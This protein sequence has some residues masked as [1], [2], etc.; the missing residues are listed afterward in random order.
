MSEE[1]SRISLLLTEKVDRLDASKDVLIV[2][3]QELKPRK[4]PIRSLREV[5]LY[6]SCSIESRAIS[7]LS[8]G[9]VPLLLLDGRGE[10]AG[11]LQPGPIKN[12]YPRKAQMES[13]FNT[14]R[15][16]EIA[17]DM[18]REKLLAMRRMTKERLEDYDET[19]FRSLEEASDLDALRGVEG[20]ATRKHYEH[21]GRWLEPSGFLF[22][23]RTKRP[24]ADPVNSML[25]L[26]YS[27]TMSTNLAAINLVGLDPAF[28]FLHEDYYGRPSL[29]CDLM[30]PWR[31]DLAERFVL[32]ICNR[33]EIR[34]DHFTYGSPAEGCLLNSEGRK[35]FFGK[36]F[37][38]LCE[39]KRRIHGH[40]V[41]ITFREAIYR[42]ARIFA[43]KLRGETNDHSKDKP[44]EP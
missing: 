37:P 22:E 2:R 30:E 1:N 18:V 31:T 9:N 40:S 23:G 8:R 11:A 14:R 36:W 27:L 43:K 42:S 33:Q 26:S 5:I 24:P 12:F 29:A 38:F 13:Y 15:R 28:G 39:D 7:V 21:L 4:Y 34:P 17:K 19:I 16:V 44:L 35:K 3:F 32:R 25:S 20:S 41:E 6:R 10:Y